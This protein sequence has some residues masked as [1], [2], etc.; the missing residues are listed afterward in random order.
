MT[1]LVS[2]ALFL[3][4]ESVLKRPEQI[5]AHGFAVNEIDQFLAE[6]AALAEPVETHFLWRPQLADITDELVLETAVN[7]RADAL[8]S[9]NVR[10]FAG[11][12]AR[13]GVKLMRPADCLGGLQDE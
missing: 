12:P 10:D 2:T 8:I 1:P 3:E 7:G 4:Y 13:F 6:L 9:H 5:A 11:V